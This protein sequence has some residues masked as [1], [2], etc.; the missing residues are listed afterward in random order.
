MY[1]FNAVV[2]LATGVVSLFTVY[3]LFRILPDLFKQKTNVE[4]E[5]E[6]RRRQE[7]ERKLAEANKGLKAF[8]YIASHDLQEPIRKISTFTDL[9]YNAYEANLDQRSKGYADKIRQSSARMQTL[10][11][12][13]LAL[14]T[15]SED[16]EFVPVDTEKAVNVAVENL[17]ISIQEKGAVINIAPLPQVM[18]NEAYLSQLF[19]NLI[20]NAIKFTEKAPV[21]NI[22]ATQ[23]GEKVFIHVAD[24]GIGMREEDKE[25]IFGAFQ[26]LHGKDKFAGTGIGLAICKRVV[27]IRGGGITVNSK[28]GEGTTF[29]IELYGTY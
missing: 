29:I 6:I 1:R 12:D 8:A 2:R 16:V 18:G 28:P 19:F 10:I 20:G 7:P 24:N 27:D 14:S 26:R 25:K 13:V 15:I 5:R 17:E 11:Q 9:L 23:S 4:L 22:T 3:H 21:V